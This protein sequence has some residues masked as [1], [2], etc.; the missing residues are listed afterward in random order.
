MKEEKSPS[1]YSK[2]HNPYTLLVKMGITF[3][4]YCDLYKKAVAGM[5][6]EEEIKF[7]R[8]LGKCFEEMFAQWVQMAMSGKAN[9][10]AVKDIMDRF[11]KVGYASEKEKATMTQRVQQYQEL[12]K[13]DNAEE[14]IK[15]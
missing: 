12:Q 6:P 14:K 8:K 9:W 1:G 15:F 4:D 13:E 3:D 7:V 10:A 5:L 11:R 2:L